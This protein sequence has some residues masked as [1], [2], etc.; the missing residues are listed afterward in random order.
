MEVFNF[1]KKGFITGLV[2]GAMAIMMM[3]SVLAAPAP[4]FTGWESSTGAPRYYLNGAVLGNVWVKYGPNFYFLNSD[5]Y[6]VPSFVINQDGIRYSAVTAYYDTDDCGKVKSVSTIYPDQYKEAKAIYN[7]GDDYAAFKQRYAGF[8]AAY[9]S[10]EAAIYQAYL[11]TYENKLPGTK[12]LGA[13][14]SYLESTYNAHRYNHH[15]ENMWD[16]STHKAYCECGAWEIQNC[17]RVDTSN[18]GPYK[19]SK[20]GQEFLFGE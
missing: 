10:N 12:Y 4:N 7:V 6:T 3:Q 1:M 17:D 18:G 2:A 20:C 5:G 19:C 8:V 13:Y 11:N 9:G 15:Y 14:Q 16:K